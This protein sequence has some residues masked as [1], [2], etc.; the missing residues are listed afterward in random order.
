MNIERLTLEEV[1][2]L[3]EGI[4]TEESFCHL[5][6]MEVLGTCHDESDEPFQYGAVLCSV[7]QWDDEDETPTTDDV[8]T[9]IIFVNEVGEWNSDIELAH[10]KLVKRIEEEY[11]LK[12]IDPYERRRLFS[13]QGDLA[14]LER[15]LTTLL[16][17]QEA[18]VPA[19]LE[20][21]IDRQNTL[22]K[23]RVQ[24]LGRDGA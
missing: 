9:R 1:A 21:F 11:T 3:A 5:L 24:S 20:K 4:L 23:N 15:H 19:L 7:L 22:K 10:D 17:K 6:G 8:D 2:Y 13:F 12:N 14:T 18:K 16:E